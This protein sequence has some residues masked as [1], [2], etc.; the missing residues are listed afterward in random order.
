MAIL[1]KRYKESER[2][3]EASSSSAELAEIPLIRAKPDKQIQLQRLNCRE[4]LLL[5]Q[6]VACVKYCY[7]RLK[8]YCTSLAKFGTIGYNPEILIRNLDDY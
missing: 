7:R 6:T 2:E 3:N 1:A 5:S 8:I 4:C